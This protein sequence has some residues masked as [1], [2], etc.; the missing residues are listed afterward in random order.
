MK[1][2][3]IVLIVALGLIRP[4]WA[5]FQDGL[6]AYQR[7][8]YQTALREWRPLAEQG[9]APAQYNIGSMYKNGHGVPQDY[10]EAARWYRRAAEQGRRGSRRT[11]CLKNA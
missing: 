2:P 7:G 10:A 5:D 6:A 3:L 11:F 4:A 1:M 8:D 9:Y